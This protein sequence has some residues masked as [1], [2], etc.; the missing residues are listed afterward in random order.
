MRFD[1]FLEEESMRA[2]LQEFLPRLLGSDVHALLDIH[3]HVHQGK[4]DLMQSLPKKIRAY[5]SFPSNTI[6][7][8]LHDQDSSDCKKLKAEISSL[9]VG[10]E[11]PYLVRIS[12]RELENWY[13][14]SIRD[15]ATL[16]PRLNISSLQG[17]AKYRDPDSLA[18]WE[19]A[20]KLL[21]EASN[22]YLS[23]VRLASEFG[24][25]INMENNNSNSFNA[26]VNGIK[27]FVESL[28]K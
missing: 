26:F 12:C 17:K 1:F 27:K 24:K 5:S 16:N 22:N 8:V 14:G 19:E 15:F 13:L 25:I 2:F 10:T 6:F 28:D 11:I 18:G 9:F 23:K 3:F 20:Q 7:V 4:R 21:G